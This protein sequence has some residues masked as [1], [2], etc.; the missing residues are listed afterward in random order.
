[1][2]KCQIG[3]GVLSIPSAFDV[4]GMIPGVICMMI[5]AA[6]STWGSYVIGEFKLNHREIYGIDDAAGIIFG[7]VGREIMGF[8]YILCKCEQ[9]IRQWLLLTHDYETVLIFVAGSGMLSVSISFNAVST[10]GTCTAVFVAVA[11]IIVICFASLRTLDRISF[12]AWAG[13][14][15]ILTSS[16]CLSLSRYGI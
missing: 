13:L 11:A 4:L 16:R 3:L 8:C 1:M 15:S 6:L 2:M 10:H 7:R 14:F 9:D 5:I 12:L